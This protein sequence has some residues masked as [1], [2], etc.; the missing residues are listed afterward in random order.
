[1]A[2]PKED[3]NMGKKIIS[4]NI[5]NATSNNLTAQ[6]ALQLQTESRTRVLC[7]IRHT[8]SQPSRATENC[9]EPA[10]SVQLARS[11]G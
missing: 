1:M 3:N 2:S 11:A 9:S 5:N 7:K 10:K 4:N 6:F 8:K